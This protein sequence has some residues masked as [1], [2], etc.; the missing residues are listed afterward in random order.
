MANPTI[1]DVARAAGV[2][3]STVSR[4]LNNKPDVAE[5]TRLR[6]LRVIEELGYT[7]D[8]RAQ[9]L[10]AGRSRAISLL[11]PIENIGLTQL[12]LDFFIGAASAAGEADFFFN[13]I[14]QP[15]TKSRLLS[16][17]RGAQIDGLVLMQ[18]AL[19]DWRVQ[20]LREHN[21][22]FV[23]IGRCD[24][25]TGLH[26]IDLDFEGAVVTA[27]D[28]LVGQGHRHIGLITYAPSWREQGFG[29]AVRVLR[30]HERACQMHGLVSPYREVSVATL[31]AYKATLDLMET[32]PDLTAFFAVDGV[33]AIG[34]TK[35]LRR[36]GRSVP[37]DA[38]VVAITTEKVAQLMSP[39]LT[40]INFPTLHMGHWAVQALISLLRGEAVEPDQVV[41]PAELI[42]RESTG[43]ARHVTATAARR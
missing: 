12:E 37:E 16:L 4:I 6:V 30:G 9:G 40:S 31:E 21:Y 8:A 27:F 26:Y 24:D 35:A 33:T 32:H 22:P 20:L 28:Y 41:L 13:L 19:H 34:V 36:K 43:P 38:S 29:P 5:S 39:P 10:A 23:M 18:I 2:S 7:P 11:Y 25:N 1:D 3:V 14:T 17:Y 42:V 15:V